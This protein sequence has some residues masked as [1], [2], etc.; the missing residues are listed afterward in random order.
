MVQGGKVMLQGWNWASLFFCARTVLLLCL[1]NIYNQVTYSSFLKREILFK[2]IGH[3]KWPNDYKHALKKFPSC[4][5][6]SF[7][8]WYSTH[9]LKYVFKNQGK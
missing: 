2:S 8:F 5:M 3:Y 9:H 7:V 1:L 6:T 4:K